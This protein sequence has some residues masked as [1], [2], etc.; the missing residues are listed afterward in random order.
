VQLGLV[1]LLWF[2]SG[3]I[4]GVLG[5]LYGLTMGV[6]GAPRAI[7]VRYLASI[8]RARPDAM[9]EYLGEDPDE[10]PV[11]LTAEE[12]AADID[13][14][15]IKGRC[16]LCGTSPAPNRYTP[17]PKRAEDALTFKLCAGCATDEG[18]R[19]CA[20]AYAKAFT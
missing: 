10:P 18:R 15:V 20:E 13:R 12:V 11:H 5:V 6:R 17:L 2:V 16:A 4:A 1:A 7:V 3:I 19:R 14:L 8:D 9:D